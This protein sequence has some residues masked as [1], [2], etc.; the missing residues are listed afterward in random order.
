MR[1]R[2][3]AAAARHRGRLAGKEAD[4]RAAFAR[5]EAVQPMSEAGFAQLYGPAAWEARWQDYRRAQEQ[6]R[7]T[8]LILGQDAAGIEAAR[9]RWDGAPEVFAAAVAADAAQREAD[10]VAYLFT[11]R[12]EVAQ[13]YAETEDPAARQWQLC[14]AQHEAGLAGEGC[15]LWTAAERAALADAWDALPPGHAGRNE[16]LAFFRDHVLAYPA[17]LRPHAIRTLVGEGIVEGTEAEIASLVVE[18]E[19]GRNNRARQIAAGLTPMPGAGPAA[20]NSSPVAG[21][22]VADVPATTPAAPTPRGL[23][24]EED[25]PEVT[26]VTKP[27]PADPLSIYR[28]RVEVVERVASVRNERDLEQVLPL[29]D[30]AF[31]DPE[32]ASLLRDMAREMASPQRVLGREPRTGRPYDFNVWAE[33]LGYY[34]DLDIAR[35]GAL[36]KEAGF[37]V[38]IDDEGQLAIGVSRSAE[39]F[40]TLAPRR[41]LQMGVGGEQE[42]AEFRLMLEVFGGTR[43][44]AEIAAEASEI[45]PETAELLLLAHSALS[46]DADPDGVFAALQ[47]SLFPPGDWQTFGELVLALSPVGRPNRRLRCGHR[48]GRLSERRDRRRARSRRGRPAPRHDRAD[49]DRQGRQ[50][51]TS[52]KQGGRPRDTGEAGRAVAGDCAG[53]DT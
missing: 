51:A 49:G 33:S 13:V 35:A 52:W 40:L 24:V 43:S 39:P 37:V 45:D 36:A 32:V 6:G 16:R 26:A 20:A 50:A 2:D 23:L 10:P 8:A 22:R 25:G 27:D 21:R 46:A 44:I 31:P 28:T 41:I 19:A 48:R 4:D 12:P 11:A 42:R 29:I 9:T 30:E 3:G 53:R 14:Q 34:R 7:A 38:S 18:L 47:M 1:R 5:G 17:D 15:L